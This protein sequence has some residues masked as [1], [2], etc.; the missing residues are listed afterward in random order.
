MSLDASEAEKLPGVKVVRDGD[1]VGVVA[2]DARTVQRALSALRA[3]WSVP[4]QFP[5]RISLII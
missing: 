1:F 5:T 3:K 2:G 4:A